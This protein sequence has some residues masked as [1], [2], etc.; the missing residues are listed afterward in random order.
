MRDREPRMFSIPSKIV[1]MIVFL[2]QTIVYHA[3]FGFS[4]K[5]KKHLT[6]LTGKAILISNHSHYLDPGFVAQ[7]IWPRRTLF[8]GM[9]KT[10]KMNRMFC[11]FISA[12]GGV[13]IPDSNPGTIIKTANT[14]IS[15][16]PYFIHL[17]PEGEMTQRN[18][19]LKPFKPG[20]FCLSVENDIPIIPIII[21]RSRRK[22]LPLDKITCYIEPA[23]YPPHIDL[24]TKGSKKHIVHS[25]SESTR[26]LIQEKLNL[27]F[28]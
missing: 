8:T 12:L 13:P 25:F 1:F 18:R 16:T 19:T 23:I 20:A 14:I 2:L 11:W 24:G 15:D 10:F 22:L 28:H 26:A 27:Y 21:C 4:I 17:F 5:G 6:V 7:A 9:E 3:L